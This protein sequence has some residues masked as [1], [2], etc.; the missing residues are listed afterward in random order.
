[1]FDDVR[2]CILLSLSARPIHQTTVYIY[3]HTS[4][5]GCGC[6]DERMLHACVG[7]VEVSPCL[8]YVVLLG[9]NICASQVGTCSTKNHELALLH[10]LNTMA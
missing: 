8:R 9:E 3:R 6:A 5:L 7:I 2:G 10:H 1:M 4:Y